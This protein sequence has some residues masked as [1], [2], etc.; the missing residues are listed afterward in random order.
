MAMRSKWMLKPAFLQAE[1]GVAALVLG[2]PVYLLT[3]PAE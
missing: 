1:A 2:I 3:R